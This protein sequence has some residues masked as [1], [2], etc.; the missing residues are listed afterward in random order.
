MATK[1][2]KITLKKNG[3]ATKSA[4]TKTRNRLM[5]IGY[6]AEDTHIKQLDA[7]AKKKGLTRAKFIRK[8]V[9]ARI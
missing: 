9:E 6:G 7:A 1:T 5:S 2:K 3:A 4:K 8:A